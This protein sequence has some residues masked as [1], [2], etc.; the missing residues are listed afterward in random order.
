MLFD[1][2]DISN[3]IVHNTAI[4]HYDDSVLDKTNK[5]NGQTVVDAS[6][7][8]NEY[9]GEWTLKTENRIARF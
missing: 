1:I 5:T 7:N 9:D 4:C 2:P 8:A 6:T 3:F